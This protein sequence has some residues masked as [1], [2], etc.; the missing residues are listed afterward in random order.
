MFAGHCGQRICARC[1]ATDFKRHELRPRQLRVIVDEIIQILKIVVAR[2]RC[3][4]C[5]YLFTDYP[6]FRTPLQALR[7]QEFDAAGTKV[8]RQRSCF[9]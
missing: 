4:S 2:W 9:L 6:D 1:Q 5:R 7:Q 3:Q 8:R